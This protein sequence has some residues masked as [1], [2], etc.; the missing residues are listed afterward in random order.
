[1]SNLFGIPE[2][3][4]IQKSARRAASQFEREFDTV[5]WPKVWRKV[6]KA[7]ALKAFKR[8]RRGHSLSVIMAGLDRIN[9]DMAAERRNRQLHPATWLNAEGFTDEP[10]PGDGVGL[11]IQEAHRRAVSKAYA[12]QCEQDRKAADALADAL[13]ALEAE[14]PDAVEAAFEQVRMA[15]GIKSHIG[16]VKITWR[17]FPAWTMEELK[18]SRNSISRKGTNE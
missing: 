13:A 2:G 15:R 17:M 5:F 18:A 12:K 14:P 7:D 4:E 9:R 16:P 10:C 1:M 3:N 8:A 6:S 11:T